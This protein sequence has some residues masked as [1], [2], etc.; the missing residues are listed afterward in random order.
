[1]TVTILIRDLYQAS[2][3]VKMAVCHRG[4][5]FCFQ[6]GNKGAQKQKQNVL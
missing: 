5:A 6:K 3:S 1:M 2:H 4:H